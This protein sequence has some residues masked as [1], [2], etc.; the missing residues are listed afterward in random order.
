M[1]L[2]Y[3]SGKSLAVV[4]KH[5]AN[6]SLTTHFPFIYCHSP[7][8]WYWQCWLWVWDVSASDYFHKSSLCLPRLLRSKSSLQFQDTVEAERVGVH[9]LAFHNKHSVVQV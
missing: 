9:A 6:I 3:F 4:Y 7:F 2:F 5:S 8:V 1:I